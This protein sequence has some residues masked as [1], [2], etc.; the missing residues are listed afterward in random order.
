MYIRIS[1]GLG[2]RELDRVS[3]K[4]EYLFGVPVIR[5]AIFGL[6]HGYVGMYRV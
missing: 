4:K 1:D 2:F 5:R 3:Y 6:I